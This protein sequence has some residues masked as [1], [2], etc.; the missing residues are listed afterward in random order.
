[1]RCAEVSG[2]AAYALRKVGGCAWRWSACAVVGVSLAAP[3]MA[4]A[5]ESPLA[6]DGYRVFAVDDGMGNFTTLG[7]AISAADEFRRTHP[8]AALRIAVGP[9]DHYVERTLEIGAALSGTPQHPTEIVAA[10]PGQPPRIIAGHRL[11]LKWTPFRNGIWRAHLTGP[12]FESLYVNGAW[13]PLARYPNFVPGQPLDGCAADT[14]SPQRTARWKNPGGG[15][16]HAMQQSR[17]GDEFIPIL[18]KRVDGS[19]IFGKTVG[20]NRPSPPPYKCSYVENI[21]EEFDAPGEWF[22]NA[23]RATLYFMPPKG[24]DPNKAKIEAGGPARVFDLHGSSKAPLRFVMV[25]GFSITHAGTSFLRAIEPLLRSDWRIAREG[26]VYLEGTE[27]VHIEDNEFV[28]LGGNAVFVSGYNRRAQIAGNDIHD[29]GGDGIDFVGRADAVRSPSFNYSQFVPL[30]QMD[31]TPGPKSDDYPA[32][33]DADDN[34]IYHIGRIQ[35][36]V[37]G[38]NID[39]AMN[40]RV[41]HNS[42][43]DVPRAGINIGDGHWGGHVIEDNDVFDTVL[44]T[45]D[46]GAFNSWGRDRFWNPDRKV[47]NAINA[48]NP[49]LWKLDVI[50]PII[51]RHNRFRCDHGWDI[52]LDDG[53]SNYRIY[54]NVLLSGGLKFRE[55]FDREAWNNVI[56]N[57]SFHPQV[58][59][60]DSGDM[61]EHNIVMATYQP[62]LMKH[63]D[64]R[65]DYNL[66]PTKQ[67]LAQ[68]RQFGVGAHSAF[69]HPQLLDPTRGDYRVA[70]SSP[71]LALGFRNFPMDTFGVTSPALKALARH[72]TFPDLISST[73]A[74]SDRTYLLL[75]AEIKTV[76]SLD[77]QSA[78]GLPKM[79]GVLVLKVSPGSPAAKSGLGPGD[80]IVEANDSQ[81]SS[82]ESIDTV[83]DLKRLV[84]VRAWRGE[85]DVVVMRNQKRRKLALPLNGR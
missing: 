4:F 68:A 3:M 85:V 15:I 29:V 75:G 14:L 51:L 57:N 77:E 49:S 30:A 73:N 41:A 31:R 10:Q 5:V 42:I 27:D 36:Q 65:I 20:N 44:E 64:A 53:S 8:N 69:G 6:A 47:M 83:D 80:V 63:W 18:G 78:A 62:V 12:A 25:K 59:F 52:D 67:A 61:F 56:V 37:A 13:E 81:G 46:N 60:A 71:A 43:Y 72:P 24:V 7:E 39:M 23:A 50:K 33:S 22:Y 82:E 26:A 19:L 2:R 21:F 45:G 76:S 66:F 58:W 17:W 84:A 38:V 1:M 54:D 28:D 35:K 79:A 55:G 11:E 9:G 32:D 74:P 48:A 34:L 16:V 40:I 70:A